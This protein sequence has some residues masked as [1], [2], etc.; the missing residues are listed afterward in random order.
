MKKQIANI[1][2]VELQ[3]RPEGFA[4]KGAA[5]DAFDVRTA[6]L[7]RLLGAEKLGYNISAVPPGKA[8]YPF[9]SHRVNE[10]M[11]LVLSGE[12]EVR[13]GDATYPLREGDVIACPPGGPET[14]HQIRNTGDDEMRFL[15]VSTQQSPEICDYPDSKKF[16]VYAQL[17]SGE[18]GSPRFF[19]FM[20]RDGTALDYW[21]GEGDDN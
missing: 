10:E 9:H 13:I 2:D 15:A 21:D 14:A 4:P 8:A 1:N 6:H 20:G 17:P 16:G 7:S 19:Y 11:F 18:D 12:G 5:A 3:P